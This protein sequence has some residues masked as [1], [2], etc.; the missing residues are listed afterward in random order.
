MLDL[1]C[2]VVDHIIMVDNTNVDGKRLEKRRVELLLVSI[3]Y[4]CYL[5]V[6]RL[7]F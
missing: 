6:F 3:R 2:Q 1:H 5:I 4:T 7:P